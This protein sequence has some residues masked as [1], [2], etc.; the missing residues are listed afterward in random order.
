MEYSWVGLVSLMTCWIVFICSEEAMFKIWLKSIE[1]KGIKNP[2]VDMAGVVAVVDED[3]GRSW[4]GLVPLILIGICPWRSLESLC[5]F[6]WSS[7]VWK[8]R[9]VELKLSWLVADRHTHTDRHTHSHTHTDTQTDLGVDLTSPFG[10]GQGQ[11]Q[12]KSL[13]N[14]TS[15]QNQA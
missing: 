3:Y 2:F 6:S 10:Q 8:L 4:L 13:N 11:G 12:M 15:N 9:Y 14:S 1:V 7:D 5:Q